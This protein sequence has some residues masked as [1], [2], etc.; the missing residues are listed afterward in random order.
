[1]PEIQTLNLFNGTNFN[2][3]IAKMYLN[4]QKFS[5]KPNKIICQ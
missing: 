3:R 2:I 4:E 1:M 5:E